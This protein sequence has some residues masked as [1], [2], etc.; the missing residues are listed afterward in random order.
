MLYE[1]NEDLIGYDPIENY[2]PEGISYSFSQEDLT[3]EPVTVLEFKN[4]ADID[5]AT[6]DNNLGLFIRSAREQAEE[7]CQRSFILRTVTFRALKCPT[8]WPLN[9]GPVGTV[10]TSGFTNFG[11]I[12]IE[13][14]NKITVVFRTAPFVNYDIK[15]AIMA[16]ALY[17]YLNRERFSEI[18]GSYNDVFVSKLKKYRNVATI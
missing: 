16:Q 5:F 3:T 8:K 7:Y 15:V 18:P 11:D 10:T 2:T 4:Y 1:E 6:D 13:G 17:L 12:L 9:F 14:G